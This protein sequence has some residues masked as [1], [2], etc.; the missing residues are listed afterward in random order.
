MRDST[1]GKKTTTVR[2]DRAAAVQETVAVVASEP[3]KL[4]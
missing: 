1:F 4:K 3:E 2:D